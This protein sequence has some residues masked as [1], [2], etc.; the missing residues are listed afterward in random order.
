MSHPFSTSYGNGRIV[1][2]QDDVIFRPRNG[3]HGKRGVIFLHGQDTSL[4]V[5]GSPALAP[6]Q[7]SVGAVV[8]SLGLAGV[9]LYAEGNGW[10]NDAT[11]A[12][13]ETART[14]LGTLG[15]ATDK[16]LLVG[17]SM[18]CV[19]SFN[20]IR[21]H[22]DRVAGMVGLIPGSDVDDLRDNNR[23]G[24]CQANINTAWGLTP[25]STSATVPL[26]A[27]ANPTANVNA[28][29]I[30]GSGAHIKLYYSSVDTVV[31]PA[32][33]TT[34][35]TKLGCTATVIDSTNGHSDATVGEAPM[36]E[37]AQ[38]LYAVA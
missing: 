16:V 27:R 29:A 32:T 4:L 3:P 1:A 30:A 5:W 13:I 33:V 35:A 34:L 28:A 17:A 24:T 6:G 26:P 11:V 7:A 8:A 15:C 10:G 31:L 22:P 36:N 37:I 2:G 18:G 21:A 9:A 19:D 38:T 23:A 12:D 14:F 20:Y 25:G